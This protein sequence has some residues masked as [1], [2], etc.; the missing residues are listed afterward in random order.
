M[1]KV[2]DKVWIRSDL[3]ELSESYLG[4]YINYKMRKYIGQCFVIYK[5]RLDGIYILINDEGKIVGSGECLMQEGWHW[6]HKCFDNLKLLK[7]FI[8]GL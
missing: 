7:E 8:N 5:I 3:N 4:I 2:G 1:Y 6:T